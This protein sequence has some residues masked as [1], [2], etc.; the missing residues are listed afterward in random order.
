M[1]VT[2]SKMAN[3]NCYIYEKNIINNHVLHELNLLKYIVWLKYFFLY[4]FTNLCISKI[5]Y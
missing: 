4:Y 3:C 1:V 2:K 5:I